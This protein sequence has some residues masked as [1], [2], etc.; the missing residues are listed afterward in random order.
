MTTHAIRWTSTLLLATGITLG[1]TAPQPDPPPLLVL[2]VGPSEGISAITFFPDGK[3]L[4]IDGADTLLWDGVTGQVRARLQGSG[5]AVSPDGRWVATVVGGYREPGQVRLW[6]ARTGRLRTTLRGHTDQVTDAE[7]SPDGR[8]LATGGADHSARLWDPESGQLRATLPVPEREVSRLSFSPD[9]RLLATSTTTTQPDGLIRPGQ[10][11]LWE[12]ESA[13][14]RVTLPGP[15]GVGM[16][17]VFSPDGQTLAT[18][19]DRGTVQ[20]W[21][22]DTGQA[23]ITLGSARFG[24]FRLAFSPDGKTLAVGGQD[25]E[26]ESGRPVPIGGW[27]YDTSSGQLKATLRNTHMVR[28]LAFSPDGRLLAT[29]SENGEVILWD[30]AGGRRLAQLPGHQWYVDALAFSPDGASLATGGL[31]KT[32]R[33]W[34]VPTRRLKLSLPGHAD[35]LW[36]HAL[37]PDGRLLAVGTTARV[38]PHPGVAWLWD[39]RTGRLTATLR[40]HEDSVRQIRFSP[41]GRTLATVSEKWQGKPGQ[42]LTRSEVR[43]W[44]PG[45]GRLKGLLPSTPAEDIMGSLLAFSPDGRSLAVATSAGGMQN[46]RR[47]TSGEIQLW[48]VTTRR[49]KATMRGHT[50]QIRVLSFSPDSNILASA[51]HD[52]TARLWDV[53]SGRERAILGGHMHFV[54]QVAFSP[55][56]KTLATG[57]GRSR[58]AGEVKLWEVPG[59]HLKAT[60]TGHRGWIYSL[61]FS[62]D[63]R[64]LATASEDGTVR[65]WDVRGARSKATLSGSGGATD[66]VAFSTDGRRLAVRERSGRVRLWQLSTGSPTPQEPGKNL[67]GFSPEMR[68][69]DRRRRRPRITAHAP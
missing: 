47:V 49:L 42:W 19:D 29:G 11:H 21:H 27:L 66:Q 43:L 45:T 67:Q 17:P 2:Q 26:F 10:T 37:S 3:T 51:G 15:S 55:D 35:L 4:S 44:D 60:L 38:S 48:D 39:L 58:S 28:A 25:A 54:T 24:L 61:A 22:T 5:G 30:A 31:D 12:T 46:R 14:L 20:F 64:T 1:S 13:R 59:G 40:G 69:H 34:D 9:G 6:E 16:K 41:D 8:V 63:S 18:A 33:L 52:R 36:T 62:P 7:F 23:K 32:V 50:D 56:G 65:L 68:P 53:A 57:S